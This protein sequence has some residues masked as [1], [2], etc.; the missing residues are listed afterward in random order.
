MYEVVIIFSGPTAKNFF[1]E[2]LYVASPQGTI[3]GDSS[4]SIENKHHERFNQKKTRFVALISFALAF[5]DA[6]ILY[7]FSSYIEETLG[8]RFVGLAYLIAFGIHLFLLLNLQKIVRRIGK[9]RSLA[10]FLGTAAMALSIPPS[11]NPGFRGVVLAVA[12]LAFSNTAWVALDVILESYSKDRLSGRI[13]GLYLTISNTG[14][15]LAPYLSTRIL[16][17]YGY[18]AIFLLVFIGYS[19]VLLLSILFFR[20]DNHADLP[21][22]RIRETFHDIII[23]PNLKNIFIISLVLEIFYTIMV[24]YMPIHL[25]HLG[26][27]WTEI[28]TILTIMLLPFVFLQYPIGILA[29]KRYGEKELLAICFL[30]TTAAMVGIAT[31]SGNDLLTWGAL[32][33]MTRVGIAGVEVLRDS[34][35]YKQIDGGDVHII[36]FFRTARPVANIVS[37][38]ISVALLSF[39]EIPALFWLVISCLFIALF[40]VFRLMDTESEFDVALRESLLP[41]DHS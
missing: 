8:T 7:T 27:S 31:Y 15:L 10:F 11:L 25:Q 9:V 30:I 40:H 33:F 34:Y 18:P 26:F 41:A 23:N 29:D 4:M 20:F 2:F 3:D 36:A 22:I 37:A 13:R 12:F 28:G 21:K 35:F 24:I 5:S 17:E 32:L 19:T 16:A 39:F 6:L 38:S 1:F 14:F